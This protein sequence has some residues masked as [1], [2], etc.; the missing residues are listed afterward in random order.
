MRVRVGVA[1]LVSVPL[2]V[3]GSE[4]AHVLAY[5]WVYPSA[6]VRLRELIATGHSYMSYAPLV[7]GVIGAV[8]L[9]ALVFAVAGGVRG[10]R[11]RSPSPW[12]FALLPPLGFTLQ[13][14]IERFLV[15]SRFPWWMVLQPTF[16]IG[17]ALQLP[18]ALIAFVLARLLLRT[19]EE[20]VRVLRGTAGAPRSRPLLEEPSWSV[21]AIWPLRSAVLADGH[22]GR[23]PPGA[24][25]RLRT[26]LDLLLTA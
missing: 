18:F 23:G 17:L 4:V 13:E 15:G 24:G 10:H 8:E 5:R 11:H 3:V 21:L 7:L 6:Q 25:R 19:A 16:R 14:F 26:S 12:V 9:A 22:A 2:M 1:W 20:V